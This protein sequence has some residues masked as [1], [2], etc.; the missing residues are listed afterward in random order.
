[1][2]SAN[3]F[4]SAPRSKWFPVSSPIISRQI[5]NN[6]RYG[7]RSG[8]ECEDFPPTQAEDREV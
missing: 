4:K 2:V 8:P 1:M 3:K 7:R 5:I 6:V